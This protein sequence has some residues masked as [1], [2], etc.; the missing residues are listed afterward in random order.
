MSQWADDKLDILQRRRLEGC[1]C[2][3]PNKFYNLVWDVLGRC[4]L[5]ITVQVQT[6]MKNGCE[7][8]D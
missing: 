1:L 4:P 8:S 2:R 5:G 7:R 3:V 6:Y